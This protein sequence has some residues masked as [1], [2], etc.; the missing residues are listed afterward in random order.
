MTKAMATRE[1]HKPLW[2]TPQDMHNQGK[3][4]KRPDN[5]APVV[6]K[7][8]KPETMTDNNKTEQN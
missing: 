3:M 7:D 2:L 4:T 1:Q 5:S 6:G 8:V